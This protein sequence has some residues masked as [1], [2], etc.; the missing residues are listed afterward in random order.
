[1]VVNRVEYAGYDIPYDTY[2][3]LIY[4]V[5]SALWSI[6]FIW[7]VGFLRLQAYHILRQKTQVA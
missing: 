7:F 6:W 1:L 5:Y 3:P 2:P 4:L